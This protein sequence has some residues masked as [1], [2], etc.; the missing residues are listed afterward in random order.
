MKATPVYRKRFNG[1]DGNKMPFLLKEKNFTE[2]DL[3]EK[4]IFSKSIL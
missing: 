2:D 4:Y 1:A 3:G